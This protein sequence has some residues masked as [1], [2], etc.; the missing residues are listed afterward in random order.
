MQYLGSINT[1]PSG[2]SKVA[3]T[4]QTW[5]QGECSHRLQSLGTKKECSIWSFAIGASGNPCI[6]PFGQS[7]IASPRVSPEP[8]FGLGMIYRSIHVRKKGPSGTP[9]S[10]LQASAHRPHPMHLLISM[11]M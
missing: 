2:A 11:H 6:P 4:G 1:A 7:T 3:P 5:T 9:F 10:F 8:G